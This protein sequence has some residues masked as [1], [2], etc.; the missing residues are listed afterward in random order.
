[1]TISVKYNPLYHI[2]M[3][4]NTSHCLL[5]IESAKNLT[6]EYTVLSI[7]YNTRSKVQL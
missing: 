6:I 1:M 7:K 2:H 3:Y 5:N 4:Q